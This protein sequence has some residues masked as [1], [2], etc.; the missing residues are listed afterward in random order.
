M[1][2]SE[3]MENKREEKAVKAEVKKVTTH[4]YHVY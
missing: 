4:T 1:N 3:R 2:D